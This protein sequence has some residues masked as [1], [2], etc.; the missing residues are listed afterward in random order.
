MSCYLVNGDFSARHNQFTTHTTCFCLLFVFLCYQW[1]YFGQMKQLYVNTLL[2]PLVFFLFEFLFSR[3][4]YSLFIRSFIEKLRH[5]TN[6]NND[7]KA[8]KFTCLLI[9]PVRKKSYKLH[10]EEYYI[11]AFFYSAYAS[12]IKM[13]FI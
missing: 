1:D 5:R 8:P 2:L 7:D 10:L 6:K 11:W 4:P 9:T 3:T 13:I 12:M